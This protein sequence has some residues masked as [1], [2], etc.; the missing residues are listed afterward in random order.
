MHVKSSTFSTGPLPLVVEP[1]DVATPSARSLVAWIG[2]NAP[3]L[4]AE[5][6][7]HGGILLRGFAVHESTDF[8][9]VAQALV[10]ELKP[11]V[12]GQSPRTK[13]TD[14]VYTSTAYP[15]QFSITLHN[16]LSYAKEPPRWLLFHCHTPC[17]VGGETAICDV[18]RV[19]E[20]VRPDVRS[21]FETKGVKYVK[22]MHGGAPGGFGKSWMDHFETSDRKEV[23]SYL[24]A[25]GIRYEWLRNGALRTI[26]IRPGVVKHPVTKET[27]WFNQANLWHISNF[28]PRR[29][30]QLMRLCGE[31]KLPTHAYFGDATVIRDEELDLVRKVMWANAIS[32]RWQRGD[33]L[34]LDNYLVAHGRNPYEGPRKILVAMG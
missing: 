9:Q 23:E 26:S 22:N 30:E 24:A 28:E 10:P 20:K 14:R 29:R 15:P 19:Y 8:Q 17:P 3:W 33:V 32:F 31:E 5:L 18:R 2:G 1:E 6:L 21:R 13:V 7:I 12:E 4:G 25:N 16:E 11:Y 27:H 34:L